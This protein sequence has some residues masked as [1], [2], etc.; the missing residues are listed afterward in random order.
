MQLAIRVGPAPMNVGAVL[1]LGG[2]PGFSADE[3]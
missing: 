2:G 3:T 1:V